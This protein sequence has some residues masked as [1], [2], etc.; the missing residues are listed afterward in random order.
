MI[1]DINDRL[2]RV[3]REIRE[4]QARQQQDSAHYPFHAEHV[5]E[6]PNPEAAYVAP[7]PRSSHAG[8]LREK[9]REPA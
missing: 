2:K 9:L 4:S 3:E 5:P 6:L 7:K 8:Q 1:E